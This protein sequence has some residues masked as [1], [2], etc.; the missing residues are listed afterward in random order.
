[1]SRPCTTA[2]GPVSYT[3]RDVYKRQLQ[4]DLGQ[5]QAQLVVGKVELHGVI[6]SSQVAIA[7]PLN[8]KE[9][10]LRRSKCKAVVNGHRA[11]NLRSIRCDHR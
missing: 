11:S 8:V 3:H 2:L 7:M 1:M 6:F 10:L 9:I 4:I 5:A